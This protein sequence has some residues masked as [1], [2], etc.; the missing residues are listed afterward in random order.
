MDPNLTP[1]ERMEGALDEIEGIAKPNYTAVARAWK[2][3]RSTLS[4]RHRGVTHS[5]Q[6]FLSEVTQALT[7]EQETV[8]VACI[9]KYTARGIPPTSQMVHNFA[10]EI[11]G[12]KIGKNWVG[13]FVKRHP[14]LKSG[15]LRNIEHT[16]TKAEYIP[17]FILFFALVMPLPFS[18]I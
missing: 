4:R 7:D 9:N 11:K 12:G 10:E 16:R 3:N 6:A 13:R 15:Y 18:F 5:R 17:N 14:E 2:I 1:D 8:L